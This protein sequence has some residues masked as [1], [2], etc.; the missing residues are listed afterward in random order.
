MTRRLSETPQE[1]AKLISAFHVLGGEQRFLEHE[2]QVTNNTDGALRNAMAFF[3]PTLL[4]SSLVWQP[5]TRS[6]GGR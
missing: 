6:K 2:K 4:H 3:R 1:T 5:A